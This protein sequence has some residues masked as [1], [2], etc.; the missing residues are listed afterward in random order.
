M[1]LKYSVFLRRIT[2]VT[3]A[4]QSNVS[5]TQRIH[6]VVWSSFSSV[7]RV[8]AE[9]GFFLDPNDEIRVS[10]LSNPTCEVMNNFKFMCILFQ[11]NQANICFLDRSSDCSPRED[12][13]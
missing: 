4:S 2:S 8:G 10:C 7:K 13:G 6:Q 12:I 11:V 5:Q 9:T 1:E 3:T